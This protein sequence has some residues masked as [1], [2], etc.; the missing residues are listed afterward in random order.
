MAGFASRSRRLRLLR[1]VQP[2]GLL[3]RKGV[4]ADGVWVRHDAGTG[5]PKPGRK[6][7]NPLCPERTGPMGSFHPPPTHWDPLRGWFLGLL[8]SWGCCRARGRL[9]VLWCA[10]S[11]GQ[12][13]GQGSGLATSHLGEP[14]SLFSL[15]HP[16]SN[17]I[18]PGGRT[19][20][21]GEAE[22]HLQVQKV[23]LPDRWTGKKVLHT[24]RGGLQDSKGCFGV[25]SL[26]INPKDAG[27]A[28][29]ALL[30][31]QG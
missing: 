21:A 23:E 16:R 10:A 30:L 14:K 2:W 29:T 13:A 9:G 3:L 25:C 4:T 20:E 8:V 15:K 1:A 6:Y 12:D 22:E 7:F 26:P 28:G 5:L 11:A 17:P 24:P 18:L 19:P 31:E 27:R